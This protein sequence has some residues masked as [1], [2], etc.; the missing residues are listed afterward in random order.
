MGA[1]RAAYYSTNATSAKIIG[2]LTIL[3]GVLVIDSYGVIS[4]AMFVTAGS[5]LLFGAGDQ[6]RTGFNLKNL[7]L[8]IAYCVIAFFA[9]G[10]GVS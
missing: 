2:A 4:A 3:F 10:V 5:I 7:A 9:L 1:I 8:I 6:I